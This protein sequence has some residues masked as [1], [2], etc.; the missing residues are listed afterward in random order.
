MIKLKALVDLLK[1]REAYGD[2]NIDINKLEYDSRKVEKSDLFFAISGFEQDGHIFINSAIE[3]GASACV[4]EKNGNYPLKAKIIVKNSREAMAQISASYFGNPSTKMKV[5]GVTGT[6]GKTTVTH[7]LRSIWEKD[8]KKT[9]LI[10]TVAHYIIKR[11]ISALNTTPESLD[12]QKMFSE[13]VSENVSCVA[14]EVS[15]H[16]LVLDRVKMVDFDAAVFTNLNPEHLDFHKNM[17]SYK[18][19]KGILFQNLKKEAYSVINIDDPEWKYF[20]QITRG[21]N[22][23]YSFDNQ[24]ADFHL[25]KYSPGASGYK[26]EISTPGGCMNLELKLS[27]EVNIYNALASTAAAFVT[28]TGL[29]KIKEGL[30]NFKGVKGRLE[31]VDLGQDFKVI[32]DYAH[33]PFAF[34][35]LLR[36]AKEIAKGRII[37][38]FGCGGDRDKSKRPIMGRI[39]DQF[40]DLVL[41]TTDNPRSEDPKKIIQQILAGVV[42]KSRVKVILDRKEAIVYA[43]RKAEKDD[44]VVLAGKGHE[45]Y[46]LIGKEKFYFCEREIIEKELK[47]SGFVYD[48]TKI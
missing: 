46:Q 1:E 5:I 41:L 43:L 35:N 32:I 3:K 24:K 20:Y 14:I 30:D 37:F 17:E 21:K 39:A 33:T 19:A 48:R 44:I 28:G 10:G 23:T 45:D 8:D 2:I 38:L 15:S 36:T 42:D 12:L 27:G 16:A 40:A 7:M 4:L 25:K 18:E 13:M 22:V 29:E 34:E 11:K 9:G 26:L 47:S 31:Q 6:N